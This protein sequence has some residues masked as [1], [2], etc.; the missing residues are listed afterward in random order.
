MESLQCVTFWDW[1]LSFSITSRH[2]S[3]LSHE[4][5]GQ[6][7]L[8]SRMP[9]C[10]CTSV[11]SIIHP[12]KDS[13]LLYE[14]SCYKLLS[15]SHA[16]SSCT[17]LWENKFLFFWYQERVQLRNAF[18]CEMVHR[19]AHPKDFAASGLWHS[20]WASKARP[21]LV[22]PSSTRGHAHAVAEPRG[23]ACFSDFELSV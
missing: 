7:S 2:L 3:K 14:K 12:Q 21:W 15:A 22:S 1:L 13:G 10:V 17:F 9:C 18:K 19:L 8:L 4:P 20:F 23:A 5:L 16:Y 11:C 6:L